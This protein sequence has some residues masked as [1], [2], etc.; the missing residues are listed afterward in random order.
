[1]TEM[2]RTNRE[3]KLAERRKSKPVYKSSLLPYYACSVE[4][5]KAVL[6]ARQLLH[7]NEFVIDLDFECNAREERQSR[8]Q[9]E[10][11][12][13]TNLKHPEGFQLHFTSVNKH[14]ELYMEYKAGLLDSR[15]CYFHEK[16]FWELFPL[17]RLVYLSPDAPK[18]KHID[19]N[20]IFVMG[21]L[22]DIDTFNQRTSFVKAKE[23]GIRAASLPIKE[24]GR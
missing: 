10:D 1:M 20:D 2:S 18:L 12:Y 19:G 9:L 22:V 14:R 8:K 23:L 15:Y 24:F 13:G 5:F 4:G 16:P 7:G 3:A 6:G 11:V 17:E 21:G